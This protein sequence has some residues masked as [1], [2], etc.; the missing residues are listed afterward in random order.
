MFYDK[1]VGKNVRKYFLVIY[2]HLRI[3]MEKSD[4]LIE[5]NS[6]S[7][8]ISGILGTA[9]IIIRVWQG[10]VCT[11]AIAP[12]ILILFVFFLFLLYKRIFPSFPFS[13]CHLLLE[14]DFP[15]YQDDK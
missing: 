5:L 8:K 12:L 10:R 1:G 3:Y 14:I 2:L 11:G 9:N 4:N 13:H 6:I 7:R 15:R